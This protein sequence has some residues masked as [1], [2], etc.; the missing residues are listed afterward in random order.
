MHVSAHVRPNFR[1]VPFHNH[2]QATTVRPAPSATSLSRLNTH[3]AGWPRHQ[4][5]FI[6]TFF[7]PPHTAGSALHHTMVQNKNQTPCGREG[8]PGKQRGDQVLGDPDA[9]VTTLR[10]QYVKSSL[11]QH[12]GSSDRI[13]FQKS[14]VLK[15][16]YLTLFAYNLTSIGYRV[17]LAQSVSGKRTALRDLDVRH[18]DTS[19]CFVTA[20]FTQ[21]AATDWPR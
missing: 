17:L 16:F 12:W 20:A 18:L 4:T 2:T 7:S 21:G 3:T 1:C 11:T 13:C 10:S 15:I 5:G 8:V 6:T 19:P 9:H 14:T